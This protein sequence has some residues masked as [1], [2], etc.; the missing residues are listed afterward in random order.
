[1]S[2][3]QHRS[4]T[5]FWQG[6]E[7]PR[8]QRPVYQGFPD[9]SL[10]LNPQLSTSIIESEQLMDEFSADDYFRITD[11]QGFSLAVANSIPG[12]SQVSLRKLVA[13]CCPMV[14]CF[15]RRSLALPVD[16]SPHS[17]CQDVRPSRLFPLCQSSGQPG[18]WQSDG[19]GGV[20]YRSFARTRLPARGSGWSAFQ[21]QRPDHPRA[22]C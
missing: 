8:M 2:S 15:L 11:L 18:W 20:G 1:M 3:I 10:A 13:P 21:W 14:F 19:S 22:G 5:T 12:F 16:R 17:R 6:R 4:T 7:R 9:R